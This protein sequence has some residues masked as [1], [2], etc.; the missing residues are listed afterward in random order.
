MFSESGQTMHGDLRP[1][2]LTSAICSRDGRQARPTRR[3]RLSFAVTSAASTLWAMCS[4]SPATILNIRLTQIQP[5]V[6]SVD[7]PRTGAYI[8][9][10]GAMETQTAVVLPP[11]IRKYSA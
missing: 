9:W 11:A 5:L 7:L 8:A 6:V 10:D 2:R 3:F 1:L 4:G